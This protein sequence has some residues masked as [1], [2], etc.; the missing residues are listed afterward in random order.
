MLK[1]KSA[2]LY[3]ALGLL[4]NTAI[5]DV[6]TFAA[7]REGD[8]RKLNFHSEPRE[9]SAETF[10]GEDGSE[11]TLAAYE[12]QITVLNFWATW[13]APCRAEMPDLADLQTQM[14]DEDLSVVT[15]ATGRNPRPA[16]E[17]FFE[18]I[19]VD[20]LPLH[21]DPR[22]TLARD[23]GVLGLPITVILDRDGNEIARL[24]GD[25]KWN[26]ENAIEILTAIRDAE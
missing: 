14:G 21:A 19:A 5:A 26:S 3:T 20:N 11:M 22:S 9:V 13:C 17:R 2:L 18:E 1:L 10:I 12:G 16:M 15:I 8:M 25:A 4:A 23:M 6:S 24:Q 7:L